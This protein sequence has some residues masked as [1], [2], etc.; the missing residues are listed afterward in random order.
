MAKAARPVPEGYHTITPQLT[1]DNAAADDR[2]VQESA[3]HR[4]PVSALRV[5]PQLP[6]AAAVWILA[7]VCGRLAGNH[8][9]TA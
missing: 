7:T 1:L 3:R 8:L 4:Y 2:L 5:M 9:Q 6:K